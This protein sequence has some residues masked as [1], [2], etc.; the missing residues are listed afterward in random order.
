MDK[1]IGIDLG[2]T[3]SVVAVVKDGRPTVIPNTDGSRVTPSVVAVNPRN[4]RWL[5]GQ[6]ARRQAITNAE[7]TVFSAK[8]F[9][10]RWY[11]D[12]EVRRD[13]R[14]AACTIRA[15]P[16]GS[17]SIRMS[18]RSC[19]PS[20]VLAR[21][22][23]RLRQDAEAWLGEPVYQAVITVPAY[24]HH[25]Q[26]LAVKNSARIAGLK[27]LRI[28]NE[29]T[30][31]ALAYGLDR[32]MDKRIAVCHLGGGTFDISIL[33][34]EGDVFEVLATGGDAHLG[35][36][37]FDQRII[38]WLCDDFQKK[39]GV[40]LS[41]DKTA[42]QRLREAAERAKCDLS[43]VHQAEISLPF[44]ITHAGVAKDLNCILERDT[45]EQLTHDL[46]K[47]VIKS[48]EQTFKD[49]RSTRDDIDEVLLIGQQ[50]RMPAVRRAIGRFFAKAPR[51]GVDPTEAAALGAAIHAGELCGGVE[52]ALLLD[53]TPLTLSVETLGGVAKPFVMR[54]TILPMSQSRIFSTA[55]DNQTSMDLK[56]YQGEKP[57]ATDNVLLGQVRLEGIPPAPRGI[58]V[59]EV[60]FDIDVDA[61]LHISARDKYTGQQKRVVLSF[62]ETA[63]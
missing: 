51:H 56:V 55:A 39:H 4:G 16:D 54:N 12:P 8:R 57:R 9:A 35:G 24:F 26:R 3:N 29:P 53:V 61:I 38:E 63:N 40:D 37:D 48:M 27:V 20:D 7:N 15:A 13:A 18:D 60:T 32:D 43:T 45:L 11:H 1:A 58:P 10:G 44:I 28:I 46:I 50:A 34:I 21:L 33:A 6:A 42:L 31:A 23:K 5:V 25:S 17:V 41:L 52:K 2:T 19:S 22:F 59:I 14:F 36:D 49:S 62:V 47:Q 30:A